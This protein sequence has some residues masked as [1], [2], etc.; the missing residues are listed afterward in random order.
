MEKIKDKQQKQQHNIFEESDSSE[1]S[2]DE[3]ACTV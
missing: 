1:N 3:V 2:D